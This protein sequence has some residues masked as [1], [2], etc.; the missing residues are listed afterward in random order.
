MEDYI[1]DYTKPKGYKT[2][3]W[4]EM[5]ARQEK[6]KGKIKKWRASS[7]GW[8]EV[9]KGKL[10]HGGFPVK[11]VRYSGGM[12]GKPYIEYTYGKY[13]EKSIRKDFVDDYLKKFMKK[14]KIPKG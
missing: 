7:G 14:F 1:I 11:K 10:M 2:K 3:D 6:L 13:K 12:W 8:F 4:L 9:K 5:E